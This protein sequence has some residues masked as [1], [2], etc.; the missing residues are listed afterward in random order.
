M[1]RLHEKPNSCLLNNFR[2]G[3]EAKY[4]IFPLLDVVAI[5]RD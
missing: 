3:E 5:S 2:I 4:A 1:Q